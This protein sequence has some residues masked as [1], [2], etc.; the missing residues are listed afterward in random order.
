V[1]NVVFNYIL[2]RDKKLLKNYFIFQRTACHFSYILQFF[3][4]SGGAVL[5]TSF[6]LFLPV[7]YSFRCRTISQYIY[8]YI[9]IYILTSVNFRCCHCGLGST[10]QSIRTEQF[11]KFMPSSLY[12]LPLLVEHVMGHK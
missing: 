11:Q 1:N 12:Q 4:Y 8:I 3:N 6:Y 7:F 9:Y 5:I 2:Y 10:L